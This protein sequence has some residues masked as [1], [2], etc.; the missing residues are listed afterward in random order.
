MIKLQPLNQQ[1]GPNELLV[2]GRSTHMPHI[3]LINLSCLYDR[4]F[5]IFTMQLQ[6]LK[7]PVEQVAS[8]GASLRIGLQL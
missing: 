8:I 4:H 2:P 1:C 5:G 3:T 7:Q 6:N